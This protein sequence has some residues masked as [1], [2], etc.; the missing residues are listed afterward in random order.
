MD[1]I[2]NFRFSS[3]KSQS[4]Q[5]LTKNITHFT[6]QVRSKNIRTSTHLTLKIICSR[7]TVKRLWIYEFSSKHVSVWCQKKIF[8]LHPFVMPQNCILEALWKQ[9][10]IYFYISPY[11]NVRS[12]DVVRF[13]L[14]G[15]GLGGGWIVLK[16]A[17]FLCLAKWFTIFHFDW[18]FW[19]FN[20]ILAF[21][22]FYL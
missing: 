9:I 14:L 13:Y 10:S 17:H 5:K 11:E 3:K 18:N 7:N 20:Y 19:K 1:I 2:F 15:D 21:R 6:M 4:Q 22:Y 12:R 16:A 8:A